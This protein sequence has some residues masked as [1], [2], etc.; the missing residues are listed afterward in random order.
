VAK[1][2]RPPP[3]PPARTDAARPA[4]P[5]ERH[6][7][8]GSASALETLQKLEKRRSAARPADNRPDDDAPSKD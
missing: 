5:T 1:P 7:G 3:V 8:E 2:R 6:S 4:W